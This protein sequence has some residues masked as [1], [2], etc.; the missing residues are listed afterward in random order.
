MGG[1]GEEEGEL[2]GKVEMDVG[3][4]GDTNRTQQD[5]ETSRRKLLMVDNWLTGL[6]DVTCQTPQPPRHAVQTT[7]EVRYGGDVSEDQEM[8]CLIIGSSD[9]SSHRYS[10]IERDE[11]VVPRPHIYKSAKTYG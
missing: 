1:V 2:E 4:A 6:C 5:Y 10:E 7:G 11:L 3:I 8:I 9:S